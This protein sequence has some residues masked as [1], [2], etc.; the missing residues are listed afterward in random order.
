VGYEI[1]YIPVGKSADAKCGD[2]IAMR[3]WDKSPDDSIVI[4][5]DGGTRDSGA[6]LVEH[7]KKYYKTEHVLC[8]LLTHPDAD[9]A[10]GVRDIVENLKV[11]SLLA[12]V[13]WSHAAEILPRVRLADARVTVDSVEKSLKE[14]FPAALE[15]IEI[16]AAKG[17]QV[18]EPF[19]EPP[20]ALSNSTTLYLL[21]PDRQYYLTSLLPFYDCLP[22]PPKPLKF[23]DM[24][25]AV[26]KAMKWVGERWDQELLLDPGPD[27][28][29]AENNSSVIIGLQH[30]GEHFLFTG[31]AGVP[32][33]MRALAAAQAM[34]VSAASFTGLFHVPHHGSRHNLGPT[35]LSQMFGPP[36]ENPYP[37]KRA[38]AFVSATVDDPKHP[39][40]RVTNALNRRAVKVFHIGKSA[41]VHRSTD[42]PDRGW[43]G[44]DAVPFY[45]RVEDVD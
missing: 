22:T 43:T 6:A 20:V 44:V 42:A 14:A 12:L 15:A 34:G 1:D 33:I 31:D 5:I 9:H 24:F 2:A 11:R 17:V 36:T 4:T 25:K 30:G 7:V 45:E 35:L 16:A 8:A 26:Q 29:S 32:A 37:V 28:V 10:S 21:A 18:L 40:R 39:S 23:G 41:I 13:P 27:D 3:F 38:T 19:S